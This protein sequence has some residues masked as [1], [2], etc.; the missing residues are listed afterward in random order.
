MKLRYIALFIDTDSGYKDPFRDNFNLNSRFVSNYLS[1]QVRKLK[2]E[3]DG[4]F[5]M[6]GVSPSLEIKH[7]CRI[8]GEKALQTRIFFDRSAYD[9]MNEF[10]KYEYYLQLLEDGYRI[11]AQHKNIPFEQ[12]LKLHQDFKANG[13]KN[14]WQHKKK[15]FKEHGIEVALNCFFT[16]FDF[17]LAITVT[18]IKSK[19]ELVSG[20]VI[21]TLPDEVCFDSLFK[22]LII[23]DNEELI[24]T[25]FQN[26]PK[27]KFL[28]SDI[29]N[30][31][32]S[33]EIINVGLEYKPYL[34]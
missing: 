19:T 12:L 2:F 21:R 7:I 27:F 34:N 23:V 16:S 11:C 30:G 22:D 4:T 25:E 28:L 24:I 26:R 3:T 13:Y 1:I 9:Q 10:E 33:F 18:D 15:R 20:I 14:E 5:H 32:F 29:L 8:V 6:L 31:K 17:R